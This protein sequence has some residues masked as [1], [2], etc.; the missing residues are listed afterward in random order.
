MSDLYS[1][2]PKRTH[3]TGFDVW[4]E[5]GHDPRLLDQDRGVGICPKCDA[6]YTISVE[7]ARRDE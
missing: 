5:D 2:S 1:E 6:E 4:C 3:R 7:V